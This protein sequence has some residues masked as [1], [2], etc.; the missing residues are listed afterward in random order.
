MAKTSNN[1]ENPNSA[2][3]STGS[4]SPNS[5]TSPRS[6]YRRLSPSE[7]ESLQRDKRE[8]TRRARELAAMDEA[9]G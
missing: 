9:R 6:S 2:M 5:A 8:T 4:P 7:I 1:G 3:G